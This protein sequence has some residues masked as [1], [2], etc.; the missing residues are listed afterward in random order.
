MDSSIRLSVEVTPHRPINN[1][2]NMSAE[3]WVED[4]DKDNSLKQKLQPEKTNIKIE[5]A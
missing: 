1:T 5:G 3:A 4:Y 2:K